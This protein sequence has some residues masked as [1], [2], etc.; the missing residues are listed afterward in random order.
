MKSYL[1]VN[2]SI[3]RLLRRIE[4]SDIDEMDLPFL[5][6]VNQDLIEFIVQER[7]GRIKLSEVTKELLLH[8]IGKIN[9]TI[10]KKNYEAGIQCT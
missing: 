9:Q 6:L 7:N 2:K 1:P 8:H 10:Q 5:K 4:L 3:R